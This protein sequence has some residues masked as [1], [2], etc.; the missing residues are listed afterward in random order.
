MAEPRDFEA[1][2]ARIALAAAGGHGF[3][4][5]GGQALIA[6]GLINRPTEDIDLFTDEVGGV[7]AAV[8]PVVAALSRA[9][10]DVREVRETS[11][12]GEVFDG[13]D[14]DMIEFEVAR[15][16]QIV[17]LE[18]VYFGRARRPVIMDIGPVLHIEDVIGTKVAALATRA[19]PRDFIDVAA[20]LTRYNREQ[21]MDLGR[22]ADPAVTEDEFA[23]AMRRLDRL[24]DTVFALYQRTPSQ[25]AEI[26]TRFAAWPR[27]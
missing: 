24:D 27:N 5:A 9:G 16:D 1:E 21:L 18:L 15:D 6:H 17:R 22:R 13:F 14:L 10:L 2:V 20:A 7:R 23:A 25:I 11:E 19:Y 8:E 12:L 3:A 4:L 26:R